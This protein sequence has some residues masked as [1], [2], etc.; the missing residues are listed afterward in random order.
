[1]A[2]VIP[3]KIFAKVYDSA[4]VFIDTLD[5]INAD[6]YE[7]KINIGYG[8]ASFTFP[9]TLGNY[10]EG[11]AIWYGNIVQLVVVDMDSGS[12]GVAV[13]SGYIAD[14]KESAQG[15]DEKVVV[16]L[17]SFTT[18]FANTPA[19]ISS[20]TLIKTAASGEALVSTVNDA[21]SREVSAVI[22][23]T[24]DLMRANNSAPQINYTAT[25]VATTAVSM[26]YKWAGQTC[27]QLLDD[28]MSFLGGSH[29]WRVDAKN[30][31][32]FSAKPTTATF[33][34][35]LGSDFTAY[36]VEK[37]T[38]DIINRIIFDNG[39]ASPSIV[40]E[41]V[42]STSR[43]KYGDRFR[44]VSDNR[45]TDITTADT[46]MNAIINANAE[47]SLRITL[48]VLDNNYQENGMGV[49]I[50]S[51][52]V[53][54]TV[55]IRGLDELNARAIKD[56]LQIVQITKHLD[57]AAVELERFSYSPNYL[58]LETARKVAELGSRGNNTALGTTAA[59]SDTGS[60]VLGFQSADYQDSEG[61]WWVKLDGTARSRT[62]YAA[63][64]QLWGTIYGSGDGSTTFGIPNTQGRALVGAGN[65]GGVILALGATTGNADHTLT[66]A[67]MPSHKHV[68]N[69]LI[70][71]NPGSAFTV[72][73]NSGDY[74]ATADSAGPGNN[75]SVII[76]KSNDMGNTGSSEA[77]NN[78]QPSFG[79]NVFVKS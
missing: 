27:K 23:K 1:M 12:D 72:N 29:Y 26:T 24:V 42:N 54:H 71:S 76:D 78:I 45:V 46:K 18:Q 43:A 67:Q 20:N 35:E 49:D 61:R 68:L 15:S 62:K 51:M 4:G 74:I 2:V 41:Y 14:Y 28:A 77:H 10:G 65:G 64:F 63:L 58:I 47:P 57:Y 40:K 79:I 7:E 55:N 52:Q 37:S 6:S 22:K 75:G 19:I 50:E 60:V 70:I 32:Q 48:S 38:N 21:A 44:Y 69:T 3:K 8:P 53:G 56:N 73:D 66:T 5:P 33:Q 17:I 13:Y 9:A 11:R 59:P 30:V 34:L 16:D 36:N 31:F 39:D 25:S